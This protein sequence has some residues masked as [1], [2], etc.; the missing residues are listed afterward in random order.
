MFLTLFQRR[1]AAVI[2]TRLPELE[3]KLRD[4]YATL[5]EMILMWYKEI[6]AGIA[7]GQVRAISGGSSRIGGGGHRILEFK[8]YLLKN[9]DKKIVGIDNDVTKFVCEIFPPTVNFEIR[10]VRVFSEAFRE[11]VLSKLGLLKDVSV[12]SRVL[13][14]LQEQSIQAWSMIRGCTSRCPLCGSKCD[15]L[16]EHGK[17]SCSHHLFPAFHGW[18]DRATGTP[19]LAFCKSED[20]YAGTY[21][22]RDGEWRQLSEYLNDSHPSWVPFPRGG[23]AGGGDFD[24][25]V[26]I[27]RAAWVNC[28]FAL[29]KY[30]TPMKASNPVQWEC[31][32]E[33]GRQ[34]TPS[35]L[36]TAKKTIRAIRAKTWTPNITAMKEVI[37]GAKSAD[38]VVVAAGGG[39]SQVTAG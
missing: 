6:S 15:C 26:T 14:S 22:C 2:A 11:Q 25:D 37:V 34:L 4:M 27:L 39:I 32:V 20:V 38:S 7:S 31:Y 16:G 5:R 13:K 36:D 23:S 24:E 9:I 3:H 17:H 35:D 33:P 21:Q 12:S 19:S 8:E 10:D 30:F 28:K 18:M 1:Q 29:E